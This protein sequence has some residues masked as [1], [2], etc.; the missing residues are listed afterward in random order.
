M[1]N[2]SKSNVEKLVRKADQLMELNGYSEA[3]VILEKVLEKDS[4]NVEAHYLLGEVLSKQ[5]DFSSAVNHLKKA[6]SL[7]P[8]HPRILHL[9]GW[10]RRFD[11]QW[12]WHTVS[13]ALLPRPRKN[14]VH[15]S[16]HPF[17]LLY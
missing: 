10:D 3:K 16:L 12:P 5:N 2:S 11:S 15:L 7:L 1:K 14:P 8:G 17:A 9:L 4:E 13:R 6:L